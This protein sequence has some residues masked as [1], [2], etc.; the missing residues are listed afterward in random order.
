MLRN[1][2]VCQPAFRTL[3]LI[4]SSRLYR[5]RRHLLQGYIETPRDLRH[6][7]AAAAAKGCD[8]SDTVNSFFVELWN[9]G[10]PFA[11]DELRSNTIDSQEYGGEIVVAGPQVVNSCAEWVTGKGA[12]VSYT[13][14]LSKDL[15]WIP[16]EPLIDL[17]ERLRSWCSQADVDTPSYSTMY[18]MW[19]ESWS[20]RLKMKPVGHM[21]KCDEC[22]TFQQLRRLAT[23]PEDHARIREN[24]MSIRSGLS[25]LPALLMHTSFFALNAPS[26]A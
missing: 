17:Y 26:V 12:T 5:L 2:I 23:S 4:G 22:Q 7:S 16:A 13:E 14:A 8:K 1:T 6:S 15:R 3:C 20:S 9:A 18:R 11:G 24:S 25:M 21:G 10:Q 19:T